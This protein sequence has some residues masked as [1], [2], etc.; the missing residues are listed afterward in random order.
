VVVVQKKKK[1]KGERKEFN[2]PANP[3]KGGTSDYVSK[4]TRRLGIY[5]LGKVKDCRRRRGLYILYSKKRKGK[6]VLS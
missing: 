5:S 1:L 2:K 4:R 6:N 3:K